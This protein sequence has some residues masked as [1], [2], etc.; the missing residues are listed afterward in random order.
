MAIK[1]LTTTITTTKAPKYRSSRLAGTFAVVYVVCQVGFL[2]VLLNRTVPTPEQQHQLIQLPMKQSISSLRADTTRLVHS[3]DEL[4][5]QVQL[6]HKE[7]S[8]EIAELKSKAREK[9]ILMSLDCGNSMLDNGTARSMF[10]E[11]AKT[12]NNN[13]DSLWR[14]LQEVW[15]LACSVM[16]KETIRAIL[17]SAVKT[18]AT[19]AS[20]HVVELWAP[21]ND[22]GIK[23]V[24][25]ELNSGNKVAEYGFESLPSGI[26]GT[27]K[28]FID[29][30]SNLGL[31][32][33]L[34]LLL[35]PGTDVI[36]IEAAAP[37]WLLQQLNL[38]LNLPPG[39]FDRHVFLVQA[40][41]GATDGDVFPMMW[42]PSSTTSTRGWTPEKEHKHDDIELLVTLRSLRSILRDSNRPPDAV[43]DFLKIDCEGCEYNAIPS[44]TEKEF[45]AVK[46]A[47]GEV[48]WS[49]I[50]DQKKPS[51]ERAKSTHERL[52]RFKNFAS[53]AKE[54]CAFPDLQVIDDHHQ[55]S[56]NRT[57]SSVSEIA[58]SL[59]DNF[60]KWAKETHLRDIADD[61]GWLS[62]ATSM[63]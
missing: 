28:L 23:T 43:I 36:S 63:A 1:G 8:A 7:L 15:R 46:M 38:R 13:T 2:V 18:K 47:V 55:E 34:V 62:N 14:N 57:V 45:N 32:S 53:Q 9:D 31:V 42:R 5:D 3:I 56:R 35:Y 50:P 6:I 48:H 51:S 20:Q 58:G 54:C 30:G 52:C 33:L 19:L 16:P 24:L 61:K 60:A 40:G 4:R 37:T 10:C 26:L 11:A 44:M 39:E 12:G 59:C 49:Y 25:Q 22:I 17:E 41:L 21:K 29:A 27:G